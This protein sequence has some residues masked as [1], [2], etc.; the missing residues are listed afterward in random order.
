MSDCFRWDPFANGKDAF[1][2]VTN[3]V[4]RHGKDAFHRVPNSVSRRGKDAFHRVTN[5]VIAVSADDERP[6]L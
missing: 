6:S 5:I 3:S 1:H 4:S 2:R